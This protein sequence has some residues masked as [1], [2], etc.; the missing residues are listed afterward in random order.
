MTPHQRCIA[1]EAIARKHAQTYEQIQEE[2]SHV[3]GFP[4]AAIKETLDDL[5]RQGVLKM[6]A[7]P[8]HNVAEGPIIPGEI[9]WGWYERGELWPKD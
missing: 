3:T 7:S 1:E 8:A 6:A 5:S 9:T 4:V 2:V